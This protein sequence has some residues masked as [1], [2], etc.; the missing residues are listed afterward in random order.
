MQ[1]I[2]RLVG[3][4]PTPT[5]EAIEAYCPKLSYTQVTLLTRGDAPRG[6]RQCGVD[7]ARPE[8]RR[9]PRCMRPPDPAS[10]GGGGAHL[11]PRARRLA[12]SPPRRAA[13]VP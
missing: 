13:S 11:A 4:E 1:E 7:V 6:S 8:R 5:E 10:Q 2:K 12:S 3:V 9:Q